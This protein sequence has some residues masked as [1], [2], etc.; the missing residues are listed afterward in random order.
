MAKNLLIIDNDEQ[1][2]A[3]IELKAQATKKGITLNC[4]PFYIGLPDGNDVINAAGK[5]DSTLVGEKFEKEY[6]SI[7]FH[8]VASDFKL[9]D[10]LIDG[11]TIIKKFNNITNT[12]KAKKILYSSELEEIV[13]DYLNDH[14]SNKKSFNETWDK[15]KTLIKIDIVDFVKR[16]EMEGKIISYIEK[17]EDDNNDF[18]VD[19]LLANGD[20]KFKALLEIYNDLN[21]NEIAE[22]ITKNDSQ[23]VNFKKKL[24]ELAIAE[25]IELKDA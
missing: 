21:L 22:K 6:G 19:N 5:I 24:I 23:S 7:R 13:Q 15:F 3:I 4:Y 14:K 8:M 9:N 16:E 17:V 11:I 20:L 1:S 25:L 10:D 12:A 18:I 2:E